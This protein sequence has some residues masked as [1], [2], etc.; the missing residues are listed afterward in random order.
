[1]GRCSGWLGVSGP[2]SHDAGICRER[3]LWRQTLFL[4]GAALGAAGTRSHL[5]HA[6]HFHTFRKADPAARRTLRGRA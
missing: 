3:K 1:M 6:G 4:V 5:Y 2:E